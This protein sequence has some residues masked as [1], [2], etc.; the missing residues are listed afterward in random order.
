MLLAEDNEINRVVAEALLARLGLQAEVAEDGR[1]AVEMAGA[2]QYAAILMDCQMPELDGYE[3][4]RLIRE[5]EHGRHTP[6]IAITAH[7]MAGDRARC[8]AAGMDD[9]LAK[10]VR[11]EALRGVIGQW[12]PELGPDAAKVRRSGG[13]TSEGEKR[14]LAVDGVDEDVV[15]QLKQ[16]LS[17]PM[18]SAL[19]DTFEQSLTQALVEIAEAARRGDRAELARLAH[20]LKGSSATIGAARLSRCCELLQVRSREDRSMPGAELLGELQATA[21]EAVPA[22]RARLV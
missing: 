13:A 9:Y 3:A 22:L 21:G 14:G 16:T 5:A 19:I 1:E 12:L 17:S 7:A 2:K 15:A 4:T 10:P 8:I 11:A 18:R 20:T 6:I